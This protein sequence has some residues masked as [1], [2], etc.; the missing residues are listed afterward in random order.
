M[1]ELNVKLSATRKPKRIFY[2]PIDHSKVV[3]KP[4]PKWA[5]DY[6]TRRDKDIFAALARADTEEN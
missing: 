1:K 2:G 4:A 5:Y 3:C 6:L